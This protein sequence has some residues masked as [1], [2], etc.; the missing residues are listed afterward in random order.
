M[1]VIR[2]KEENVELHMVLLVG[3]L[4]VNAVTSLYILG[5]QRSLSQNKLANIAPLFHLGV[6]PQDS[7]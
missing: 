2:R 1:M 6:E 3:S 4:L 7:L 5:Q